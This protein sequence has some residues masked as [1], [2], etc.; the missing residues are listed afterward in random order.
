MKNNPFLCWPTRGVAI[1]TGTFNMILFLPFV[2]ILGHIHRK[3]LV[4]L[5][6][7]T[8]AWMTIHWTINLFGIFVYAKGIVCQFRLAFSLAVLMLEALVA[9]AHLSA[10]CIDSVNWFAKR[11]VLVV[12]F[13]GQTVATIVTVTAKARTVRSFADF[14]AKLM[15]LLTALGKQRITYSI[16][17]IMN[18]FSCRILRTE[19]SS[20][21]GTLF[22]PKRSF[23]SMVYSRS[24]SSIGKRD[25]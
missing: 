8:F 11:L 2:L 20:F 21:G 1:K 14:W 6:H 4:T 7:V 17:E 19:L 10:L 24:L 22:R 18:T 9:D 15:N 23:A 12:M 3:L 13:V 25:K 5:A 16:C